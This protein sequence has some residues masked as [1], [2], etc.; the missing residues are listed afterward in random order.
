MPSMQQL[1]DGLLGCSKTL[2]H[3]DC[4]SCYSSQ[5]VPL[6]LALRRDTK[7]SYLLMLMHREDLSI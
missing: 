7:H 2:K 5:T 4:M 1:R 6:R 3:V